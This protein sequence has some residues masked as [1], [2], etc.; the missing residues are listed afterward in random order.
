MLFEKIQEDLK[1]AQLSKDEVKVLTLRLLVSE[2][3]NSKISLGHDLSDEEVVAVAQKEAKK[4]KESITSFK[5]AGRADLS[6]KEEAELQVLKTYLPAQ[7]GDD[8]LNEIIIQAISETGATSTADMGK[9]IGL[10]ISRV[11]GQADGG[12]VSSIV[13]SKLS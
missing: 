3:K 13:K 9:V 10:V 12:R 2:I 5:Q 11:K 6:A 8:E 4:R 7:M 1:Q